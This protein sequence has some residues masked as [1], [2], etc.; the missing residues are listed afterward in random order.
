MQMLTFHSFTMGDVEDPEIYAA[1]PLNEFMESKKG[2]W[3]RE[4]C[5]DPMYRVQPDGM[6]WGHRI[7]VYGTVDDKSATEFLLRWAKFD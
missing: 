6:S 3:V 5:A 1:V 4:H 7:V 2:Q